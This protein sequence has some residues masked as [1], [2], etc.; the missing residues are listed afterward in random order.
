MKSTVVGVVAGAAVLFTGCGR[1]DGALTTPPSAARPADAAALPDQVVLRAPGLFP[2]GVVWD[3]ARRRFL[4]TSV[5]KGTVTAVRDDGAHE[6]LTDGRDLTSA[7]GIVIDEPR[8]R[9]LVAGGDFG[10]AFD[11]ASKGQAKLAVYDLA[12]GTR[13]RL[14]DLAAL[15]P[16]GG[17]HLANDVAVD[18]DGTAYVTDSLAPV[19]YKVAPD[20]TAGVFLT[21]TRL[22]PPA[23]ELG[24]NG[25]EYH[26]DGFLLVAMG[27]ARTLYRV[28]LDQPAAFAEVTLSEPFAG[29]GLALRADG[30][31]FAAAPY[32]GEAL[33]LASADG[34]R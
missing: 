30:R 17:R 31:L 6:T 20:G 21:D 2:E 18:R 13:T 3:A 14:V 5:T 16:A 27:S 28:P 10:A 1:P 24:L 26:P 33:E 12:T 22:K 4:V 29:D 9:M 15:D 25:V 32:A 34:W 19:I 11:P 23:G 8:G 7:I